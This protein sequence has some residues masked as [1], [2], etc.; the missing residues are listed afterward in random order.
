MNL[1][2][3]GCELLVSKVCM[4]FMTD[5]ERLY[6]P[7]RVNENVEQ[8]L[9]TD[10]ELHNEES[11]GTRED[12]STY[13]DFSIT[14]P[15]FNSELASYKHLNRQM[16]GLLELALE[17]KDSLF[18]EMGERDSDYCSSWF[19]VHGYSRLCLTSAIYKYCE[20]TG[21]DWWNEV[22]D[23]NVLV[24]NF[25]DLRCYLTPDGIVLC[26]ERYEILAGASGSPTFEI[27]Y[28]LFED[29]FK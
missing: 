9:D 4:E 18:Q 2:G 10:G 29:I 17:D 25:D 21:M 23:N 11:F 7:G 13:G 26:Y 15:K 24:K 5:E 6:Y 16:E 14:L 20:M 27:L 1:D 12:E 22:F 28:K 19:R 3:S 8:Y